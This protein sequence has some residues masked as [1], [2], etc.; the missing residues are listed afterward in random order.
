MVKQVGMIKHYKKTAIVTLTLAAL[1]REKGFQNHSDKYYTL[2]HTT[3]EDG[4]ILDNIENSWC[5]NQ[6]TMCAE[7]PRLD[8]VQDW[9]EKEHNIILE[10]VYTKRIE[11]HRSSWHYTISI[12]T[13]R[14]FRTKVTPSLYR[15]VALAKAIR[16]ALDKIK[17]FNN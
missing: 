15:R 3:F 6:G 7:A 10:S 1:L 14:L 11:S 4:I 8:E 5:N 2:G 9:L 16:E 13:G 12:N 17:Q